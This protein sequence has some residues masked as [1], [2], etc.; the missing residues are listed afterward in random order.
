VKSPNRAQSAHGKIWAIRILNMQA[1]LQKPRGTSPDRFTS[2]L[3][4]V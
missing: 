4:P 2:L 3:A 1:G